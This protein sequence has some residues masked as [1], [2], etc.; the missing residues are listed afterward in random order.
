MSAHD[1]GFHLSMIKVERRKNYRMKAIY[2][3]VSRSLGKKV[4]ESIPQIGYSRDISAWG[5]YFYTR[6]KIVLGD[7][8]TLTIHLSPE[9]EE[10]SYPPKLEGEGKVIRV[11]NEFESL[12]AGYTHGVAVEFAKKV[13][14]S[15]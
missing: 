3:I 6:S 12:P 13:E 9:W 15:F 4:S 14:V 8:L 10:E 7:R 11:E 5:T 2:F 1:Q